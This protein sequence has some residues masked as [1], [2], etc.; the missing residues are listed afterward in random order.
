MLSLRNHEN[1][2]SK[3]RT[4]SRNIAGNNVTDL[5][6]HAS[7]FINNN[8]SGNTVTIRPVVDEYN[9]IAL[10]DSNVTQAGH[11]ITPV[12]PQRMNAPSPIYGDTSG[13]NQQNLSVSSNLV[14]PDRNRG[15]GGLIH[16]VESDII[17]EQHTPRDID[18]KNKE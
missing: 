1:H 9:I 13:D 18:S 10:Q 17:N 11:P 14:S 7:S 8:P 6:E 15:K 4:Q 2:T 5:E 3:D 16:I 12:I